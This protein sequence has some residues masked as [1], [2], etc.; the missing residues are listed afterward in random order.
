MKKIEG[1][2]WNST[3]QIKYQIM[4]IQEKIYGFGSQQKPDFYI[5]NFVDRKKLISNERK[6][7]KEVK[8]DENFCIRYPDG[9]KGLNIKTAL[10][11]DCRDAWEKII[12]RIK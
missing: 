4:L 8:I 1:E 12:K 10:L 5:L 3:T 9:W 11:D 7:C 6:E 2:I